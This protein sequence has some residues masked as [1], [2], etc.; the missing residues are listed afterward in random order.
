MKISKVGLAG[1]LI[2]FAIFLIF[3]GVLQDCQAREN[4]SNILPLTLPALIAASQ[5]GAGNAEGRLS[6]QQQGDRL[7]ITSSKT[8]TWK[9]E[10][11]IGSGA[12]GGGGAIGLYIP[13]S[14]TKSI[15]EREPYKTCCSGLGLDNLEWRW[16]DANYNG[17][18]G[19]VGYTSNVQSFTIIEETSGLVVFSLNGTW[20]G[21]SRFTRTTT[22][23]PD[24]YTTKVSATYSG[25]P[26]SDAMWWLIGLYHE[27]KIDAVGVAV[28]DEDTGPIPL[29]FTPESRSP[30]PSGI[31]LP[32]EF[33]YPLITDL[34]TPA[35]MRLKVI[36]FAENQGIPLYYEKFDSDFFGGAY[37]MIYPRWGN[38]LNN[39]TYNFEWRWRFT[40]EEILTQ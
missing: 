32:Y 33:I 31:T 25:T 7:F 34:S 35:S 39:R 30:L 1:G 22:V 28:R 40:P 38:V 37:Y 23:T 3:S 11:A 24:G 17:T 4:G 14:S 21:I 20:D 19:S 8:P 9:V 6:V 12:P 10:F 29:R 18:R 26:S 2:F 16:R 15:V 36:H 13:A 5:Q 27:D